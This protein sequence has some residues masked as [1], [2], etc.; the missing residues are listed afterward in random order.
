MRLG[1]IKHRGHM[2]LGEIKYR[3][4]ILKCVYIT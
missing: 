4:E 3:D 1:E 2:R